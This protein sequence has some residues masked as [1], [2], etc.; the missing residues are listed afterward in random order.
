MFFTQL[1]II[2]SISQLVA[3][4]SVICD[5]ENKILRTRCR[6]VLENNGIVFIAFSLGYKFLMKHED[7][8]EKFPNLEFKLKEKQRMPVILNQHSKD[9]SSSLVIRAESGTRVSGDFFFEQKFQTLLEKKPVYVFVHKKKGVFQ[10]QIFVLEACRMRMENQ[11]LMKVEKSM[12]V[13]V[14]GKEANK[15]EVTQI[16]KSG[17]ENYSMTNYEL[18]EF[19]AVGFEI[20]DNLDFYINE[21][22]SSKPENIQGAIYLTMAVALIYLITLIIFLVRIKKMF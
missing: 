5:P 6:K 18:E 11:V 7:L 15:D 9:D 10:S 13:L 2:W 14:I 19:Q 21:C 16:L 12:L 8:G 1:S 4:S 17:N 20:C 3:T 22:V